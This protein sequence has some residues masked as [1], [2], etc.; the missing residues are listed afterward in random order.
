MDVVKFD[1]GPVLITP[2][3]LGDDRGFF[4]E[5]YKERAFS[6]AVDGARFVQDNQSLSTEFGTIR[7]L[8][9]QTSPMA[10]G[11]LVR[12]LRGAILDVAVDIRHGSPTYGQHVKV[13]LSATNWS[14]LWIP[15]GF[16]HGFCTLEPNTEVLYK[17]TEYYS[18]ENDRGIAFD[19]SALGI[20]WP[21]GRDKAILSDKDKI[22]PRLA[23]SPRYFEY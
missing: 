15:V 5:T 1:S 6:D 17:V 16:A 14:Q 13:E 2:K 9:F 12:V 8:H 19:D 3:K 7:G 23:D 22:Q 18:K 21:V 11:K 4:S 20:D 10:Q